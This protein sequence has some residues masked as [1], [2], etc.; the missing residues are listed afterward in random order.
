M[1]VLDRIEIVE[2]DIADYPADL[3]IMKYADGNHGADLAVAQAIGFQLQVPA[4]ELWFQPGDG[5]KAKE[6][7][8]LGVGSLFDFRYDAI[9]DFGRRLILTAMERP[10]ARV[11]STTIHG[12]GYG[13]DEVEAFRSELLGLSDTMGLQVPDMLERIVFV[14][15]SRGR[16]NR[17]KKELEGLRKALAAVEPRPRPKP[18]P[19]KADNYNDFGDFF[20]D[21]FGDSAVPEPVPDSDP[22]GSDIPLPTAPAPVPLPMPAH[23]DPWADLELSPQSDARPATGTPLPELPVSVSGPP[24]LWESPDEK[25]KLFVAMPYDDKYEDEY[26]IGFEEAARPLGFLC[27]NLK[28]EFYTGDIVDEIQRRIEGSVGMIAL[29]NDKNPNVFLEIGYAMALDKPIIFVAE[30]DMEI[31]FDIRNMRRITY[32]GIRE[33]RKSMGAALEALKEQV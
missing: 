32:S 8:F 30:K 19:E 27:E 26:Y 28:N 11:I 22:F 5:T 14:E 2:G 21:P 6:V 18:K 13:L 16:V 15:Q 17:L 7:V 12:P 23:D 25:P 24:G 10:T 20:D 33:L 3:M 4:G 1:S 29:L 31:P 9:R